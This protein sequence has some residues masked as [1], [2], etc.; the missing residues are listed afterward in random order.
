[1]ILAGLNGGSSD[2]FRKGSPAAPDLRIS[3]D[4][5]IG[6][7]TES[8]RRSYLQETPVLKHLGGWVAPV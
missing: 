5:K 6:G 7:V 1:M 2:E 3:Q 8:H 4:R